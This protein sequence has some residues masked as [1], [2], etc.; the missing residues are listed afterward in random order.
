MESPWQDHFILKFVEYLVIFD[1]I[2]FADPETG[3][4]GG[5]LESSRTSRKKAAKLNRSWE[6]GN[7]PNGQVFKNH[8]VYSSNLRAS[9]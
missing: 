7:R 8:S 4:S 5:K 3:G 9:F 2:N 1:L 6:S